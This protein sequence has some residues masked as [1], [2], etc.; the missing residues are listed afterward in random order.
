VHELAARQ[1]T[2]QRD[3]GLTIPARRNPPS[4]A[5]AAKNGYL[6]LQQLVG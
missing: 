6:D 4:T 5:F 2:S 3:L 1:T